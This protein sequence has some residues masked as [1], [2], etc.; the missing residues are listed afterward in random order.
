[1]NEATARIKINHMLDRA[2]WRF[3]PEGNKPANIRLESSVEIKQ[4]DL[5]AFGEDFEKTS[6]GFIDFLLL[7]SNGFPLVVLEAKSEDKNPLTAKEQARRY[8][9]SLDC[10]FV[11]LSNG[12]LHYFWDLDQG[13]PHVIT[14]FP[15]PDSVGQYQQFAPSPERMTDERVEADYIA[16]TQRPGYAS[17]A[18]WRNEDERASFIRAQGLRFLRDYQVRAVHALQDAVSKG[19]NRFLFEMATGHGQ[20][21]GFSRH[22]QALP[23]HLQC[24]P[25]SV[26]G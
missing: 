25:D 11:I 2:G 13:N 8:A 15:G 17:E 24:A 9:R 4:T 5:D 14:G 26:S 3:F 19:N 22:Y 1:M 6:E 7:D 23:A 18:A 16:L 12:N 10:R 21:A 20:D